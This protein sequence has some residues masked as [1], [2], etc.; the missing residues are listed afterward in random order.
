MKKD[1]GSC[2]SCLV[3]RLV[4]EKIIRGR[5]SVRCTHK[6]C[7]AGWSEDATEEEIVAQ[8]EEARKRVQDSLK[9][10]ER[11][12]ITRQPHQLGLFGGR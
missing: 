11:R 5:R 10:R 8:A 4:S 2:Q 3:G 9:A 1:H 6:H 12:K 7:R